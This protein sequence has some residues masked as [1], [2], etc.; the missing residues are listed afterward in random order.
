MPLPT[1]YPVVVIV[2]V[3]VDV[4]VV[5][6]AVVV[7]V[8][9]A[10]IVVVVVVVVVVVD[11]GGKVT[12][13]EVKHLGAAEASALFRIFSLKRNFPLVEHRLEV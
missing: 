7:D 10:V 9:V 6:D 1:F 8:V 11:D 5:F 4:V 2:V 12:G 3:V 13:S